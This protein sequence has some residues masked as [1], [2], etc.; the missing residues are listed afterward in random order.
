MFAVALAAVDCLGLRV[1]DLVAGYWL[2]GVAMEVGLLA[3][4]R[5]HGRGRRFWVGFEATGLGL[6]LAY[7]AG[8]QVGHRAV[9]GWAYRVTE[10][11]YGSMLRLPPNTFVWCLEHGLV[12][13]PRK[14]LKVYEMIALFE[15]AYGF[16][17]LLLAGVGGALAA[18]LGSRRAPR[19][20]ARP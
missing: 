9:N 5:Y 6:L 12:V 8:T 1:A 19:A 15:V 3:M 7:V 17:M 2:I 13:D 4:P 16:P 10:S 11:L 18:W 20:F 14:P